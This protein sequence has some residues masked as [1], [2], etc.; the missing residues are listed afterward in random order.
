MHVAMQIV[1]VGVEP[2]LGTLDVTADLCNDPPETASKVHL[3]KRATSWA[4]R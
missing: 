1:A 3:D 2:V 4:A